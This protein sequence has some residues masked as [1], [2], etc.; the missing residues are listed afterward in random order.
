MTRKRYG[1]G[2]VVGPEVGRA[3]ID[4]LAT[5]I[6]L[7]NAPVV[8]RYAMRRGELVQVG[9]QDDTEVANR[10]R[11]MI[12]RFLSKGR[13]ELSLQQRDLPRG[14]TF[15]LKPSKKGPLV[16]WDTGTMMGNATLDLAF[17]LASP[18]AKR[19]LRRCPGC[20]HYFLRQG[21][22]EHC[23]PRCARRVYMRRYRAAG[24]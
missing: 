23:T 17:A 14:I 8:S 20:D 9:R 12:A 4:R 19:R 21:K 5:T 10:L 16:S 24:R 11:A 18:E 7:V 6:A 2:R 3:A 1:E 15:A 13:V 22:A